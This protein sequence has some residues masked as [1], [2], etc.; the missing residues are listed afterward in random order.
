MKK[1]IILCCA[2]LSACSSLVEYQPVETINHIR[3]DSGYRTKNAVVS[4]DENLIILMFSGGGSRAAALGYGV[5]ESF[6]NTRIR[7]SQKGGSLL[8]NI[9]M[10]YGVSGG[11]VLATYFSLQGSDVVPKF[12]DNFLKKNFQSEV[13]SQVFSFS[14]LP[15]LTSPQFGR[16]DL[17]QEQFD[18]ALYK[19]KTFGDLAKNR[20]GP[21]AVISATDMNVGQRIAFTQEFFDGLCL[22][23]SDLPIARAVAA[24]SAVPLVFS[25]LTLNNNAGNCRFSMQELDLVIASANKDESQRAKNIAELQKILSLYQNSAE[26][27]YIHLV[28][29]GLTDNLGLAG[30]VDIYDVAGPELMHK[31]TL[32]SGLKRIIVININAQNEVTNEIDKSADVPATAYVI[33]TVINVPID[34]N[35][36]TTLRRFREFTDEWNTFMSKMPMNKRVNMHFVS[37]GLKDLP[38]SELKKDVLNI[39]TS[40]YLPHSDVNKLKRAANILLQNSKEYQEILKILQ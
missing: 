25:P 10:V 3:L 21:F 8:D 29:G 1:L 13:I 24:S 4:A 9:D 5:L 26:R 39:S 16:G 2:L 17:L 20:K 35:T 34:R 40:F 15:R 32:E 6:K 11:S 33:N 27:P 31:K 37:L 14:N 18:L 19:G 22:N 38:E 12:E 23:L 28:D 30:L 7:R 36:Q